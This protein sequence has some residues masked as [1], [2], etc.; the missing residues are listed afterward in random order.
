[1]SGFGIK[2]CLRQASSAW[3]CF[4]TKNK[5]REFQTFNNKYVRFFI[6]KA[7]KGGKVAALNRYFESNQCEKI[8]NTIKNN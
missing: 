2:D 3:K 5:D 6:R 8:L 4:E 1:M 7:I